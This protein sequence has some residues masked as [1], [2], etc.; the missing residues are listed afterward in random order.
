MQHPELRMVQG[1][2]LDELAHQGELNSLL[3][4]MQLQK[5]CILFSYCKATTVKN[6]IGYFVVQS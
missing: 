5:S 2:D 6:H 4:A 1:L 3:V